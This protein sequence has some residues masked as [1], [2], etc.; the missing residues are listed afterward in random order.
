MPKPSQYSLIRSTRNSL[1][2]P[3]NN[4]KM[5]KSTTLPRPNTAII[6]KKNSNNKSIIVTVQLLPS[7]PSAL[8]DYS[9]RAEGRDA[10]ASRVDNVQWPALEAPV[11]LRF[12]CAF[13][14]AGQ[15]RLGAEG[16]RLIGGADGDDGRRHIRNSCSSNAFDISNILKDI[17][18]Y[19]LTIVWF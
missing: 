5:K 7:S 11:D 15:L 3:A 8:T 6:N 2:I 1:S 12:W 13:G 17:I 9:Q 10:V 4:L 18:N 16:K 19:F 14:F